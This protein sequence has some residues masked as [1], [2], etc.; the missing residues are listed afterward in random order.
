MRVNLQ[1]LQFM[2]YQ[3]M[4]RVAIS[5]IMKKFDKHTAFRT[6][7]S[8][9]PT[10]TE[11]PFM[12]QDLAKATCFTVSTELLAIIPQLD[13][14]L[15][16]VCFSIS[17]KPVRLRCNH[18]FCIRCLVVMQRA[19]ENQCPLCRAEVVMEAT[20]CKFSSPSLS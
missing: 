1:L 16:P 8:L 12:V 7:Q 17:F 19:R 2:K 14:Y 13:D 11:S 15:C 5:K 4:N 20:R 3:E 6:Q 10:L 9:P 18:V